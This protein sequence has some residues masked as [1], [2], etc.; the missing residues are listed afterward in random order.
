M[1]LDL[2]IQ[3]AVEL[4]RSTLIDALSEPIRGRVSAFRRFRR[5]RGT[6]AAIR[7]VHY[8]NRERLLHR[9]RTEEGADL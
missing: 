4:V 2:F 5:V 1:I 9:L 7:H 8:R 6:G 3:F